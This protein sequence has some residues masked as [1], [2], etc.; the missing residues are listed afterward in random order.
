MR[1]SGDQM[2]GGVGDENQRGA[3]ALLRACLAFL[4]LT[5]AA[6]ASITQRASP[7]S[8][9]CAGGDCVAGPGVSGVY[10]FVEPEA[11]AAPVLAAIRG[12]T[13]S[14]WIEMYLLTNLDVIH[15]LEDAAHRSVETRVLL[16][17]NPY[18]ASDVSPRLLSE[19]LTAAGVQ[20]RPANPTYTFTHAKTMLIDGATAYIMTCNLTKSALGGSASATNREYA[21]IDTNAEDATA[22]AAIFQ[23]DWEYTQP[24]VR[25]ANLVVSPINSRTKLTS[26]ID[27][28]QKTLLIEQEEMADAGIEDRLIAAAQTRP[29]LMNKLRTSQSPALNS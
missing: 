7:A 21:I 9:P 19:E 18:G 1:T 29:Y 11:K 16:E 14:I 8:A 3:S 10:V 24:V 12:A 5:L 22:I 28:A 26:L 13:R 27:S 25:D 17:M 23:A 20:V 6:C 4:L 2:S 15:A